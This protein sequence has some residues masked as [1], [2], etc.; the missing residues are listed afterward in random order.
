MPC[1]TIRSKSL[2]TDW[3]V[4]LSSRDWNKLLVN[5]INDSPVVFKIV[6]NLFSEPFC[7][8]DRIDLS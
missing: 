7:H 5:Y 6:G 8:Y 1:Y 4:K 3:E 2:Q